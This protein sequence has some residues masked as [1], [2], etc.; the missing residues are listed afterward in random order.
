MQNTSNY[1]LSYLHV[2][3]QTPHLG[4]ENLLDHL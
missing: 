4:L 2:K 1:S 3:S